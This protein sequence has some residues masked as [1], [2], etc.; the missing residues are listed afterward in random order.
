MCVAIVNSEC[1]Q[2]FLETL[3]YQC[4]ASG[5]TIFLDNA[6]IHKSNKIVNF[7]KTENINYKF[8]SPYSPDFNPIELFFN[9]IKGTYRST[10][11]KY[12]LEM[13]T[14]LPENAT[15]EIDDLIIN[16]I[17]VQDNMHHLRN[18]VNHSLEIINE[19]KKHI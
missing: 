7:L 8:L 14:L 13:D 4:I 15:I 18:Y 9:S 1:F 6:S 3:K 5:C 12:L 17:N 16:S 10:R 11:N 2:K 19:I